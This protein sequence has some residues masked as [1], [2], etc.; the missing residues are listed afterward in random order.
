MFFGSR[1]GFDNSS[2]ELES[3]TVAFGIVVFRVHS[4]FETFEFCQYCVLLGFGE[5]DRHIY[6]ELGMGMK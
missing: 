6:L 5:C 2:G 1:E 3:V 4:F